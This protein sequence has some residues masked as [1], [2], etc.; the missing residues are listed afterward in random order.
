MVKDL[1]YLKIILFLLVELLVGTYGN[2]LES[3]HFSK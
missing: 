2:I 3:E 1:H